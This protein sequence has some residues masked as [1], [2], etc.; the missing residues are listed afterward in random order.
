VENLSHKIISLAAVTVSIIAVQFLA[1]RVV[2]LRHPGPTGIYIM[3]LPVGFNCVGWDLPP[4]IV[5][6][7]VVG[8]LFTLLW[9]VREPKSQNES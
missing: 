9:G 8:G 4:L 2:D 7:W 3:L 6:T 1:K 5:A